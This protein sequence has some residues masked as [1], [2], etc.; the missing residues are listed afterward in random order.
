MNITSAFHFIFRSDHAKKWWRQF[1]IL[2]SLESE[3]RNPLKYYLLLLFIHSFLCKGTWNVNRNN[4]NYSNY[5]RQS[6]GS[7]R[8][9]SWQVKAAYKLNQT[10]KTYKC[11][12]LFIFKKKISH[13]FSN[14]LLQSLFVNT[15]NAWRLHKKSLYSLSTKSER[16]KICHQDLKNIYFMFLLRIIKFGNFN[17]TLFIV[18][19]ILVQLTDVYAYFL[20][21]W[22]VHRTISDDTCNTNM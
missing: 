12:Y 5:S 3:G 1:L 9:Y 13:F 11:T 20:N 16:K 7:L 18:F 4:Y 6:C 2:F 22:S 19:S 10:K 21:S 14:F 17:F 8:K 15:T